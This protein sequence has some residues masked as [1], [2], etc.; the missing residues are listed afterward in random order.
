MGWVEEESDVAGKRVDQDREGGSIGA[1]QNPNTLPGL[2]PLIQVHADLHQVIQLAQVPVGQHGLRPGQGNK[3]SLNPRSLPNVYTVG[4]TLAL[5]HCYVGLAT[6]LIKSQGKS[7]LEH[8]AALLKQHVVS[9][10]AQFPTRML[11]S[12]HA[13]FVSLLLLQ[14]AFEQ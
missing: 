13:I 8:S 11:S 14:N 9:S 1:Y 3:C 2:D 5:I 12:T 10:L 4:T 6:S 7:S